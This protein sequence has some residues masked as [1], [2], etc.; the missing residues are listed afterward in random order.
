MKTVQGA[1]VF[2]SGTQGAGV[3]SSEKNEK[4]K[5]V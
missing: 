4:K 5:K 2:S 1:G 3:F